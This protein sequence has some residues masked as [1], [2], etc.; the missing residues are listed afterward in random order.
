ML[1]GPLMK[2]GGDILRVQSSH[3]S[4]DKLLHEFY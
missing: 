1:G 2:E 4:C 3:R